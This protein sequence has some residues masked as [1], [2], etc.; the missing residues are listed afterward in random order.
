ERKLQRLFRRGDACRMIKRC[1]DFG[2]G[3]VSVAIGELAEGLFIELDRVPK[4]Y[5]GLDGTE[6]AIAES[7]ERMAC[8]VA[9]EDVD[10]FI[11]LAHEE[12]LEATPVATVTGD[13]RVRMVWQG[14]TIV[15][16]S[17][18]FLDSNGAPKHARAQVTPGIEWDPDT[19][20]E[21]DTIAQR[22][23]SV[24][25]DL[26]VCSNKGLSERFDSTVGAATVL[27]PFGG[28]TQ[29]TGNQAMVAKLPVPGET[30]TCSGLAWGFNPYL[31]AGD[32][33]VGAY[34]AVVESVCKLVASGFK[35]ENAYLSFQEYFEKLRND[36]KRWGKP[37][38]ALLGALMAQVDLGVGAIGGKDSMSGS[39]EQLDVPPTLVSFATAVGDVDA[40]VS[41]EFKAPKHQLILVLP[42]YDENTGLPSKQGLLDAIGLVESLVDKRDA[43]AIYTPGY[44][45]LAEALFKM[46]VGNRIGVELS[47][48]LDPELLFTPMY[49]SFLVE[50]E[51]TRGF[52][53]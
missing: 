34:T 9:A 21:G 25:T 23:H 10:A 29:L 11:A 1:N 22:L 44:G 33:Y 51:R 47:E 35:R 28:K 53:R 15:D 4:K 3:G 6:L 36:P 45:C 30:H 37:T 19:Q 42:A 5:D 14:Q 50:L 46:S 39:F 38:A 40:V 7:Q 16:V 26:N 43:A 24:L 13:A 41:P 32:Q 52:A 48:V 18:A 49:G 20:W 17:R 31:S 12:N 2:A 27:M 8:A